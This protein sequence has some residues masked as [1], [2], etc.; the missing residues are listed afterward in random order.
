MNYLYPTVMLIAGLTITYLVLTSPDTGIA[1]VWLAV[2]GG[3]LWP[4]SFILYL[5]ESN[6]W[7]S[8]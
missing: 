2:I 6:K 5:K 7:S 3:M 8:K 1:P 4:T